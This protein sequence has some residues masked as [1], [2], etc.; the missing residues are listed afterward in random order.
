MSYRLLRFVFFLFDPEKIHD[1][2]VQLLSLRPVQW[3]LSLVYHYEHPRLEREFFGIRFKNPVGIAA[4]FDKNGKA[5]L[6]LQA[7][8]A[9]FL[10]VGTVT[11]QPQSGDKKPRILRFKEQKAL[12]NWM[13]FNNDGVDRVIGRIERV[14]P[15]IKIPIGLNIGKGTGTPLEDAAVDYMAC[16]ERAYRA[17]DFFVVNVSSPNTAQLRDLQAEAYLSPLLSR[18]KLASTEIA[19]KYHMKERPMLLKLSPD[20]SD[21]EISQ[22]IHACKKQRISGI[23]A[24]NTTTEYTLLPAHG[25]ALGG[26]SGQPL[27]NKSENCLKLLKRL[28]ALNFPMIGVG[29]I[30]SARDAL[31]RIEAGASLIELFTGLIYEGPSLIKKIKQTL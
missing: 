7:L 12:V 1:V 22:I 8:G 9:G 10:E 20:L 2:I 11:P 19:G 4:G 17:I 29:G 18:L 23:V 3:F 13:G 16:M 25:M 5:I 31:S 21:A 15:K 26:I 6:G 28:G 27:K 30:A 24:T 14:R